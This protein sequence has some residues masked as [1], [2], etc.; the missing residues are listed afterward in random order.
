MQD[1]IDALVEEQAL[2]AAVIGRLV[3]GTGMQVYSERQLL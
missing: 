1:L 3:A 2:C